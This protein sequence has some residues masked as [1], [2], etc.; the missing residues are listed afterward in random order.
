MSNSQTRPFGSH[1]AGFVPTVSCLLR[2]RIIRS[3]CQYRQNIDT[4]YTEIESGLYVERSLMALGATLCLLSGSVPAALASVDEYTPTVSQT[5]L[6]ADEMNIQK[7][8][9][10]SSRS[11]VSI[12]DATT[13]GRLAVRQGAVE[14]PEGNGSGFVYDKEGHI[15]TNYHVIGNTLNSLGERMSS[16]DKPLARV[17]VLQ[18]DGSQKSH[19]GYIVGADKE[20]DLV[21]LKINAPQEELQPLKFGDSS[22]VK[23]GQ[24]VV[25]IG[26]PFGF[27]HTLTKGIVSALGRG[28]Q[29]QTGSII[30][31]GIQTDAAINPGNSGGPLIDSSGRLIGVN[32]AIF[33]NTGVSTRVGFSIPS[34]TVASVVPQL[35][36]NGT[37]SRPSLGIQIASDSIARGFDVTDGVLIQ[38][39]DSQGPAALAGL[40]STRRELSGIVPGD[41]IIA[42]DNKSIHNA[43]DISSVLDQKASGQE[44]KVT[45]CRKLGV[46]DRGT[47]QTATVKLQ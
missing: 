39:M 30:G 24:T 36:S 15:V 8:Y 4:I 26:T 17:L 47:T 43:F 20:R 6:S 44:V 11:V 7:I 32:T 9:E 28:F 38:S 10:T 27:D 1:V 18:A 19:D 3:G 41:V 13:A 29:S 25:A 40:Q 5:V 45:Y 46:G 37:V 31:G 42:I 16:Y 14:V 2:H 12:F 34:N 23:M 33:T 35:I 22:Q 21:V